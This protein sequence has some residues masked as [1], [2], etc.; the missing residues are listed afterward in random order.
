M[1]V[2]GFAIGA[3][4]LAGQLYQ[5]SMKCYP[6]NCKTRNSVHQWPKNLMLQIESATMPEEPPMRLLETK[7]TSRRLISI[8]DKSLFLA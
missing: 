2:I 5:A 1:E 6:M 7:I 8:F 3:V 4:R